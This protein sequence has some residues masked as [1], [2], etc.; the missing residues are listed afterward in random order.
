MLEISNAVTYVFLFISLYFEVFLLITYFENR[1]DMKKE[2]QGLSKNKLK[3][4]PSVTIMVPC[5]NEEKTITKT[6]NSLLDLDYPKNKL[7]I[8]IIDDGSTDNTWNIIQKFKNKT[9]IQMFRKE[10]GGKYTALNFGLSHAK[11]ELIGCLDADSYVH[12]DALKNIVHYFEDKETMSVTPSVKVWKPKKIIQ[13]IQ[14]VEYDWGVFIRKM[15]SYLGAIYVTP[16]PFSIFR[17]DVFKNLGGYRHAYQTED[18]ELAVRMQTNHYKIVN[19]H[20]AIVYTVAPDTVKK[21]YKQRLRWTYGFIKN[22]IDYR[23]LFKKEYGNLGILV[24]P[25]ASIS[26]VSALYIISMAIINVIFQVFGFY[27]K[28]SAVGFELTK[29]HLNF[30]WFFINTSFM[31]IISVVS[32]IGILIL[33]FIAR[34]MTEKK[35][36]FGMDLVYFLTLYAFISPL[37]M[38][39][40]VYNA[41]FSVKTYWR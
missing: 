34:K 39:K 33:L 18:M 20:E 11:S 22:V 15:F 10:N 28:W 17:K 38:F 2:T 26:I 7:S 9:Q 12:K 41:I 32:I 27:S 16:G 13:M 35:F 4:I 40:A 29:P 37:W 24:L 36:A 21:L 3:K 6:L 23:H 14:K 31:T 1:I 25:L 30:D 19:A 8:M 5:W